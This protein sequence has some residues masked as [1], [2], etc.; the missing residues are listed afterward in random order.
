MDKE[1]SDTKCAYNKE[2]ESNMNPM[3]YYHA[4]SV[5]I[6][7]ISE[8][9]PISSSAHLT[10]LSWINGESLTL[11]DKIT[12]HLGSL[13]ALMI[14]YRQFIFESFLGIGSCLF[15]LFNNPFDLF[16]DLLAEWE[17]KSMFGKILIITLPGAMAG[18]F[19]NDY[20]TTLHIPL[21]I[22]STS[23]IGGGLL[24]FADYYK[25]S[26][27]IETSTKDLLSN[28]QAFLIGLFQIAALIPGMSRMGT[29]ITASRYLGLTRL[30]AT[31]LAFI[32]AMPMIAGAVLLNWSKFPKINTIFVPT[33]VITIIS[34]LMIH[35][36]VYLATKIR[37]IWF[38]FYRIILG[39]GILYFLFMI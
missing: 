4:L 6:Q 29:I 32:T 3:F 37:Y 9:L 28:S 8:F 24:I 14:Y 22:G 15:S 26:S 1:D 23:I 16:L 10:I 27:H 19:L 20:A 12:L 34:Y 17:R 35:L 13:F 31:H 11:T 39:L 21:V 38:G 7:S 30:E 18:F 25:R 36:M 33:L 5:F 2:E